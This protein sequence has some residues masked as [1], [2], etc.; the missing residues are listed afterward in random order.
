MKLLLL[1]AMIW[2]TASARPEIYKENE[3][4]QY[5]RSSTDEGSKSG[6]YGAQR[7]NMGGNYE[8]AHNM[9]GLAQHQ[10]SGL[11]KQVDGE[12]GEG[13]NTRAG[14]VFAAA[15]SRGTYGS[16][17]YDL[18]NLQGRNFGEGTHFDNSQS[19]S[20]LSSHNSGY[21][22]ESS[23]DSSRYS[24]S[25]QLQNS[26]YSGY[27]GYHGSESYG[28]GLQSGNL[29]SLDN[30]RTAST[31][32]AREQSAYN[33]GH[34]T[35]SAYEGEGSYGNTNANGYSSS[36][37][38]QNRLIWTVPVRIVGRPGSRVAI[39]VGVQNY[40]ASHSA[41]SF[42][43]NAHSATS[44]DQNAINSEAEILDNSNRQ[45]EY[46]PS[47]SATR[48]YESSYNYRKQ[49][50]KH[51]TK[52]EV[53]AL[54]MPTENPLPKTS[55]L[56]ED[57]VSLHSH[58][59][60]QASNSLNSNYQGAYNTKSGSSQSRH[61]GYNSQYGASSGANSNAYTQDA[62]NTGSSGAANFVSD[63]N[64]KPKSYHSAYSYH[65]SWERQ[66]DPYEIKPVGEGTTGQES[67]RLTS[68]TNNQGFSSHSYG[69]HHQSHKSYSSQ[70]NLD[71]DCDEN[72][73]VRVTRSVRQ[74]SQNNLIDL[75]NLGQQTQD[76]NQGFGPERM[77]TWN[78]NFRSRDQDFKKD[79][80]QQTENL[81]HQPQNSWGQGFDKQED[82]GQQSRDLGQQTQ[83]GWEQGFDKL[84]DLG[85]QSQDLGQQRN[86][87]W[88]Q[89]FEKLEDLGQHSQDLGQQSQNG[90]DQGLGQ[91]SQNGWGQ[92]LNKLEDLEQPTQ[93]LEHRTQNSWG[94]GFDKL[95]D[96]GQQ[97][98]DL[99]QQTF[100]KGEHLR[101][102]SYNNVHHQNV[103]Q[104][105]DLQNLGQQS[106]SEWNF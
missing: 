25:R 90:W 89:G 21:A 61:S 54:S 8:K 10:M 15:N 6:Y 36:T 32:K 16:G 7:G 70:N 91:Q 37:Y 64:S 104:W 86:N 38:P 31:H 88:D 26:G 97:S 78:E 80:G 45:T 83:S 102:Q 60:H 101:Q 96:L 22:G 44:F 52:P 33:S 82:L 93:N 1:I 79:L 57:T 2:V 49:W 4:F 14:D 73:H 99:G 65:K 67:Q 58:N 105:N 98:Q 72:G 18:G 13:H 12:L 5:S 71:S 9:D 53:V 35:Q 41:T 24:S 55:E 63:V 56:Q 103:N 29:Q 74:Q 59:R 43:Q 20:S 77:Q 94:Q 27:S 17:K 51:D 3:D 39:P 69:Q 42:D 85:Q 66:G 48:Q 92:G 62:H 47:K 30:T 106:Q 50:E 76:L 46:Q 40:D 28:Q 75:G 23:S 100:D 11:V 34:Y 68:A 19:H 84:E 81:G 87:G 95:D